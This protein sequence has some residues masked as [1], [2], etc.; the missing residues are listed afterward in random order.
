M[1]Q[2]LGTIDS[3]DIPTPQPGVPPQPEEATVVAT[4]QWPSTG[5]MTVKL[6]PAATTELAV[7]L[8]RVMVDQG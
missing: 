5:T 6:Y 7:G 2:V 3:I 4:L 1:I 8:C